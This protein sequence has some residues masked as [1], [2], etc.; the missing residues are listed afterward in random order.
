MSLEKDAIKL[1]KK[2]RGKIEIISKYKVKTQKVLSLL[3]TPGV[4]AISKEIMKSKNKVFDY[5]SKWNTIAI[6]TD[7]SRNLG[8]GN[9]G[10]EAALPVME[11]KS[12]LFK[13]FGN[14]DAFPI[15]LKT[16]DPDKII[17]ITKEISTVFGGINVEDIESPKCLR[18]T[19]RLTEELDIPVFH[20]DQHGTGIVVLAALI[21]ALKLQGKYLDDSKIVIA[22]AG[23]AGYGIARLLFK[24][25]AKYLIVTDSEGMLYEG[26]PKNMNEYKD[27]LTLITKGT[28]GSIYK[29]LDN[30]DVFIGVS[31][32]SNMLKKDMIKMMSYHPI[33]FALT[34]PD[35]EI[36]PEKAKKYGAQIIATGRS[37]YPNQVNNALVFP[38]IFRAALDVRAKEINEKMRLAAAFALADMVGDKLNENYI[39]PN[40]TQIKIYNPIVDAVKKAAKKTKVARKI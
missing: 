29:A 38:S 20:D 27:I 14:V 13:L 11:G 19:D 9:T 3:Y 31:G 39:L 37:D 7:G 26:R 32:V 36:L 4:A 25:G 24:A 16:Q 22:G 6:V 30:A 1:H 40:L 34:N 8:L 10:P 2:L 5:T 23:A 21:N 28:R 33:V 35:P 12:I 15:C 18:I 17:E